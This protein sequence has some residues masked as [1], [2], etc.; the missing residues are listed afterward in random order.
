M[1]MDDIATVG[2]DKFHH[3]LLKSRH[4]KDVADMKVS[5]NYLSIGILGL[6]LLCF[7]LVVGWQTAES[8]YAN[9]VRV[10]YV[11]LDPKGSYTVE[12][13]DEA[14]PVDFFVNTV[15]SKISEYIEKRFSK[16]KATISTDYGFANL[17]MSPQ[18]SNSF[19]SDKKAASQ[20][21]EHVACDKCADEEFSVR[22]IQGLT[23]DVVSGGNSDAQYTTLVFARLRKRS[24]EGYVTECSNKM[25][26]LLWHFRGKEDVVS[27]RD[28]LRFNPLG[29]EILREDV[30]DD[31]TPVN[32]TDCSKD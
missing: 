5:R 1:M 6:V 31:P 23:G 3:K 25:V 19:L 11:K 13:E 24:S 4:V 27:K 21:A 16:R 9:N 32:I 17:F 12:Y 15:N 28:Q 30:K 10:S 18:L 8:R 29:M 26:T 20:A 14:K 7:A 22:T 2:R